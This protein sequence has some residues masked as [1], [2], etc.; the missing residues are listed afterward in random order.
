MKHLFI[1]LLLL[2]TIVTCFGQNTDSLKKVISGNYPPQKRLKAAV[3]LANYLS[4]KN[5]NETFAVAKAGLALA[6]RTNDKKAAGLFLEDIGRAFYLRTVYDSATYYL[7]QSA[8]IFEK[9][10]DKT[11]LANIY[12]ELADLYF[13][14]KQ[15]ANAAAFYSKAIANTSK[16]KS[17]RTVIGLLDQLGTVYESEYSYR[18]ALKYF[19]QGFDIKDSLDIAQKTKDNTSE[20]FSRDFIG[21]VFGS[22]KGKAA[23][24]QDI[25]KTIEL[26]KSLNDTL[27]LAINYLNLGI[28]YKEKRQYAKSLDA[29][30]SS[31]QDAAII[32]YNSLES[33]ALNELADLYEQMG[34]YQQSLVYFKKH[35]A[36]D[37]AVY[38][39]TG[40]K[41]IDE[42]QTKYEITQREEQI[43]QQQFEISKRNYWMAGIG[44]ILLLSLLLSYNYYKQ[45]KLKERN[46]AMQAIIETE[47][48]ERKRIAQDLH[49]SVSQTMSAAKINLTV[50]GGELQFINDE[51]RK[52]YQKAIRLVDDG[53]K[54]VRT[55]SHN[56]MPWALLET[57]LSLVIKQF[58]ENI[59]ND[60]ISI[61]FFSKGFEEHFDDT[62]ETILYR[63]LQECV[64]NVMKHAGAS[65]LDISLMRDEENISMTIEDNGKG[66]DM[67]D[68]ERYI[69]MGLKNMQARISFLKGKIELDSTPGKGTLVSVYIPVA[70]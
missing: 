64:N 20:A 53:F 52:R 16:N 61:N 4:K 66:F 41:D 7:N 33:N 29:L 2:I 36:L 9:S 14:V 55:I 57:G 23:S 30:Q 50:V 15:P 11:V 47:E 34:N 12:R 27:A 13:K 25:L 63:V 40:S 60:A 26:R 65:R 44:I 32:K 39:R 8:A 31:L 38:S 54:E 48:K 46:I 58:I 49:D 19:K 28:L 18:E 22:M 35:I 24:E 43:L 5:T 51:Q 62:I 67:G 45:S 3:E 56:M 21:D 37:D 68:P 59:E 70:K 69:G 1:F 42:L 10:K 17:P 6:R